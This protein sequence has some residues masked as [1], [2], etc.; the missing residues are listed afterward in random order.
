MSED[1]HS[2]SETEYK[3]YLYEQ[4]PD[5]PRFSFWMSLD[6]AGEMALYD[7][8]PEGD[9]M[10]LCPDDNSDYGGQ[11]P[12]ETFENL[13]GQLMGNGIDVG[14]LT[15]LPP[16]E[17]YFVRV[18]HGTVEQN[19]DGIPSPLWAYMHDCHEELAGGANV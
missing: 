17:E 14:E 16:H 5:D 9:G 15:T 2:T 10:W 1:K 7:R 4:D 18:I 6:G 13:L 19:P 11:A 3:F 8:P 12:S